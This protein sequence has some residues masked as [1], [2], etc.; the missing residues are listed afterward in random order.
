[1]NK[2]SNNLKLAERGAI[3]SILAYLLLSTTKLATGHILN[4]SSLVADG[5]NN[6]SDIISNVALLIGIRLARQPAD[7]DHKFGHWKIEDLASL[8]TSIIMF[9]VGFDVLRDTVQKILSNEEVQIDPLG[10]GVGLLSALV[11]FGVYLYN[12]NLSKR[13]NSKALKAA[14]KDNISDAVTSLGTSI[15]IIASALNYPIID[16]LV[17]IVITFFILKTAYD[18]FT[19]SSFSLSDG[20]DDS[21]LADYEKAILEIPKVARVKSQRGRTYGSNIYLDVVLEMNPDL[22]VYESHAITEE[23]EQLLKDKFD[24]FDTDVHVEPSSIPEDEVLDNVLQKLKIYEQRLYAQQ[25]YDTLLADNFTLINEIGQESHKEDL[26][27]AQKDNQI[28]FKDFEIESIS[29]KTKLIRYELNGQIHTSI[30][31]RHEHWQKIFHQ[32]TSK[33]E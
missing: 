22:S 10:A 16:K 13:A 18:I 8:V 17:A 25:E 7:R 19:E 15:A 9:Y 26:L 14:A 32:I 27:Q 4:S 5:F 30:W 12:L 28:Q 11:M 23:V 1:M 29:Q 24:V 20:F 3:I 21:L 33:S 2:A 6:L 31:R